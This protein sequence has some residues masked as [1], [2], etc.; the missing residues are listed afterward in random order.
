MRPNDKSALKMKY[1]WISLLKYIFEWPSAVFMSIIKK[2]WKPE[3]Y[4]T[5]SNASKQQ[6]EG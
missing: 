4:K 5:N 2:N 3:N 1:P 6:K